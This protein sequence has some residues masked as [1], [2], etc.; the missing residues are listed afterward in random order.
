MLKSAVRILT[1]VTDEQWPCFLRE[2]SVCIKFY[3]DAFIFHQIMS[4]ATNIQVIWTISQ[5][6]NVENK[7][8]NRIKAILIFSR[9]SQHKER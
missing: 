1:L 6:Q 3:L 7:Q 2:V 9:E 4:L 8:D 5:N